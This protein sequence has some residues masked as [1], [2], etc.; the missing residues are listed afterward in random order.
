MVDYSRDQQLSDLSTLHRDAIRRGDEAERRRWADAL[1]R[2]DGDDYVQS[3][4]E[5]VECARL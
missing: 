5:R 2:F 3:A 4:R 1:N